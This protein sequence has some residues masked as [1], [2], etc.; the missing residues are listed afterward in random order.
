V[1]RARGWQIALIAIGAAL[2]AAIAVVLVDRAWTS[3]HKPAT[4]AA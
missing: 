4:A 1:N 2:F 3:R